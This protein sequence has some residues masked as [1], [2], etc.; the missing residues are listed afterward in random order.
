MKKHSFQFVLWSFFAFIL[1]L[2]EF[3]KIPN[4][5][6][7]SLISANSFAGI[8]PVK[9]EHS[10][11]TTT[12]S[13]TQ[14]IIIRSTVSDPHSHDNTSQQEEISA[15]SPS[16]EFDQKLEEAVEEDFLDPKNAIMDKDGFVPFSHFSRILFLGKSINKVYNFVAKLFP[17]SDDESIDA[18]NL[19]KKFNALQA[20]Q[21][22]FYLL[23][24]DDENFGKEV[25]QLFQNSEKIRFGFRD[26]MIFFGFNDIYTQICEKQN[27]GNQLFV[28]LKKCI[29]E[30]IEEFK[31]SSSDLLRAIYLLRNID[32]YLYSELIQYENDYS[33]ASVIQTDNDKI[34][35]GQKMLTVFLNL[36]IKLTSMFEDI[37]TGVSVGFKLRAKIAD[38]LKKMSV[39]DKLSHEKQN[40][41]IEA[42]TR[43]EERNLI[44]FLNS[45][46]IF[47]V[48][49]LVFGLFSL[50]F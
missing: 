11:S 2:S 22:L 34:S 14:R 19:D 27:T 24:H 5:K 18:A 38:K 16:G 8:K 41:L 42:Y 21:R 30:D 35:Q 36:K 40:E 45:Q 50:N 28:L 9:L 31:K 33:D 49:W 25:D 17:T 47:I 10:L 4:R 15:D 37:G 20:S 26:G 13:Y 48:G 6:T 32:K 29:E 39:I 1:H 43:T 23:Y 46:R 44:E 12:K 3:N 7:V